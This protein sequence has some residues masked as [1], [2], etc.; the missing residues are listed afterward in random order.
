[1]VPEIGDKIQRQYKY[2]MLNNELL[3]KESSANTALTAA[4]PH[5][6]SFNTN[7]TV[8]HFKCRLAATMEFLDSFVSSRKYTFFFLPFLRMLIIVRENMKLF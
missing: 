4:G 6:R 7:R 1:V 3:L 2:S 8:A 5:S